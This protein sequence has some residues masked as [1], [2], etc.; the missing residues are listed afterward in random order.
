MSNQK[1]PEHWC[2]L[3]DEQ[4]AELVAM[5]DGRIVSRKAWG[6]VFQ[7]LERVKG[8][9]TVILTLAA[10]WTIFGDA[11]AAGLNAWL[12]GKN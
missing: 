1:P 8:I 12:N 2:D 10:L 4:R 7:R 6:A 11:I 3:T 5:A 9:G